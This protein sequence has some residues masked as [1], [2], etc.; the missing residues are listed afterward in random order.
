MNKQSSQIRRRKDYA[1]E[2]LVAALLARPTYTFGDVFQVVNERLK[3][4]KVSSVGEEML[5]L[6]VYERLQTFVSQGLVKKAGQE[7]TAVRSA[8]QALAAQM[9]ATKAYKEKRKQEMAAAQ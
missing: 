1:S 8:V 6:R 3:A 4:R 5:R 9:E 7:Y 2:E